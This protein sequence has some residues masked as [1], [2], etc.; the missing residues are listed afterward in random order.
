MKSML[1]IAC[2]IIL[3]CAC[4]NGSSQEQSA[5]SDTKQTSVDTNA[6]AEQANNS[7]E[8][9]IDSKDTTDKY[10]ND[11]KLEYEDNNMAVK[12]R[13]SYQKRAA[14]RFLINAFCGKPSGYVWNVIESCC[15]KS[16]LPLKSI[17]SNIVLRKNRENRKFTVAF[18]V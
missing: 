17:N 1:I 14:I 15:S 16:I 3:L 9:E 18:L 5:Q 13:N 12:Y 7:S 11:G 6:D 8:E 10:M 4:G 2:C